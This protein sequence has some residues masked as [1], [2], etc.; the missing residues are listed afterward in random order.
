[1]NYPYEPTS[2][3]RAL[4][5]TLDPTA[6]IERAVSGW[7]Y[8]INEERLF[9][10]AGEEAIRD[11]DIVIANNLLPAD[12]RPNLEDVV[13]SERYS[14][15]VQS[16]WHRTEELGRSLRQERVGSLRRKSVTSLM[17]LINTVQQLTE[18][19]RK[20]DGLLAETR[21]LEGK[22]DEAMPPGAS[23]DVAGTAKRTD[24]IRARLNAAR[25]PRRDSRVPR[26]R[27]TGEARPRASPVARAS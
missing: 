20:L 3:A 6:V 21:E 18:L 10:Q 13:E 7:L 4:G 2:S 12:K 14:I 24:D 11:Q 5:Q 27:G 26:R 16:S 15:K 9:K 17:Q 8:V 23:A 25:W 19:N 22:P 1:M